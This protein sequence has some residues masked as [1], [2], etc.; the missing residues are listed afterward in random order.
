[1]HVYDVSFV[2]FLLF[3]YITVVIFHIFK[4]LRVFTRSFQNVFSL[5]VYA[6]LMFMIVITLY[7]NK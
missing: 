6:C 4:S 2:K 5:F 1:M 3:L 7:V